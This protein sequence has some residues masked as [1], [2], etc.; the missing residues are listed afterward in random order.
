MLI[1]ARVLR[2]SGP[3]EKNKT[4]SMKI[5]ILL[6][7]ILFFTK[8]PA[9]CDSTY[10]RNTASFV[11]DMALLD[12]S[13]MVGVGDNGQVI[14]STDGGKSWR[15]ISTFQRNILTAVHAA[16]DSVLYAVGWNRT[17]LKSEDQ[18]ESWF[19]LYATIT[20]VPFAEYGSNGDVFFLDE[21]KG[22]VVGDD[23]LLFST[24]NGGRSWKDTAFATTGTGRLTCITF[25]NDSLGF[26]CNE[27]KDIYRT[28]DGGATWEH[29]DLGSVG[30]GKYIKKLS[31]L[32]VNTGFALGANSTLLKT[33]NG[34][35]TWK[36]VNAPY[37]GGFQDISFI[38]PQTGFLGAAYQGTVVL[39]TTDG[40]ENWN[41]S[42]FQ[43]GI[44]L[45]MATDPQRKKIVFAGGG[46]NGSLVGHD[47]RMIFSTTDGGNNYQHWS[48]N[49]L[50]HFYDV[51]FLNDSTGFISGSN[52]TVYKTYDYG[53]SWKEMGV[54]PSLQNDA[55]E[56]I[57]FL[58]EQYGFASTDRV[59]KT[60][61]G[62]RSWDITT[63][64]GD[65]LQYQP[66]KMYF[67]DRMSGVVLDRYTAY[68]TI[69]GGA[70][71]A[72]VLNSQFLLGD[73]TFTGNG[74]GF[75]VGTEGQLYTSTDKGTT[76]T[77]FNLHSQD[78]LSSVYFYSDNIGFIGTNKGYLFKTLDGGTTWQKI[79]TSTANGPINVVME[80]FY[81]LNDSVG[82]VVKNN[83]FGISAIEKTKDG[84]QS[85]FL[86]KSILESLYR[87]SG[88]TH[89]YIA[90]STGFIY[91]SDSLRR[92]GSPGYIYGVEPYCQNASSGFLTGSLQGVNYNWSLSGGGSSSFYG[93]KDTVRW[94]LPGS[95][96]LSVHLSNACG[97]GP[98]T[99][100]NIIVHPTTVIQTQ[101]LSRSAC[102]GSEAS[103][104]VNATGA[105]LTYQW[106]KEGVDITGATSAV[107]TIPKVE[108]ANAGH[109]AITVTGL[110]GI[111]TSSQATLEVLD[112]VSCATA[113]SPVNSLI[114][115]AVL[116]P[117]VVHDRTVLKI[118][119]S[120]PANIDWVVIDVNGRIVMRFSHS[121]AR[122]ENTINLSFDK[123][124]SGIYQMQGLL[125]NKPV[126]I[127]RFI[128]I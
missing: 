46:G 75:A 31:F 27:G 62:G 80:S 83:Q 2:S 9:Q 5:A 107:Y 125:K 17:I 13:I 99:S 104:S 110:C 18:G 25:V 57:F 87:I 54:V 71:W 78:Y 7:A 84:G 37:S 59:Y 70:T 68:K 127:I 53:E 42:S 95:Y 6:L 92:P 51:F 108:K 96:T 16:T 29:L 89:V 52:G 85:W 24:T 98:A 41:I 11:S 49:I 50:R 60:S 113:V 33:T 23:G 91:K 56:N 120:A 19:P 63:I 101:P 103:F 102:A 48:A 65:Q 35:D 94:N 111:L 21:N 106:K 26:L 126:E 119:V 109:Y 115:Q 61:N 79:I 66:R 93:N 73:L 3:E 4:N 64:P 58:D 28:R 40:G 67:F 118:A 81:F 20:S 117:N 8:A 86:V 88:F 1:Y 114:N 76:W 124:H 34:G 74:K 43:P 45:A 12:T 77:A 82:Y 30:Y 44:L 10:F 32:D 128:K 105:A 116:M 90:G 55:V 69:D 15:N 39:K 100:T 121:L 112:S 123:L 38:N 22:F 122:G 14:K 36:I 47:G 72:L 97:A